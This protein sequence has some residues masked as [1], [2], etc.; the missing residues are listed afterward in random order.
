MRPKKL[1]AIR[2]TALLTLLSIPALQ[3]LAQSGDAQPRIT[4]AVDETKLTL[5]KGNTY[6]LARPEYDQGA[7][8]PS[9]PME[10]MLLV[11]K[12]SPQQEAALEKLMAE[13]LDKSSPNFHRW[14]TPE[15]LGKQF[16]PSD[17]DIQT[18]TSWLGSHGFQIVEVSHGRTVID[19][20]GNAG[21]VQEA[22]H[23]TIHSYIVKSQQHWANSSDPQIPTALS[24]VVAGV[25]TL[26]N[27]PRNPAKVH[28][29]EFRKSKETGKVTA[30]ATANPNF[31]FAGACLGPGTDCYAVG[32]TD[33]AT[34]YNVL[35]RWTAGNDGTGVTI[36]VVGQTDINPQ[37]NASFRSIFG[38]PASH[39]IITQN[40]NTPDPGTIGPG[41]NDDEAEANI[42]TQWSGAVATG[43]TIN[44]VKSAETNAGQGV[45][46]SA[47]YI[48][49][50][51]LAPIMTES[52]GLCEA[53]LGTAGNLFYYQLW[54]QAAGQ[55]I[56]VFI[57]TG[58][59]GSATCDFDT[60]VT[61]A[62]YG[63][64]V[65]GFAST[66]FDVAVGGTDFNDAITQSQYWSA[67]NASGTQTSAL[68]YIPE[69]VWNNTCSSV[70]LVDF[71]FSSDPVTNC[72][73]SQVIQDFQGVA[74]SGGGGGVSVCTQ[75][76]GTDV[77]SCLGGY[78]KPSWQAGPG[79]PVDGKR[80]VPDVSLF[81][82]NGFFNGSFYVI[83]QMDAN[84]GTGSSTSSCDLNSPFFDF[85]GYGG[86]SVATPAMAGIMA[87][88]VQQTG[89]AAQGNPNA[90][91]YAMAKQS[92][93][94]CNSNG[95]QTGSCIYHNLQSGAG[96]N[97][98]P[99]E[100]KTPNCTVTGSNTVGVLP[101]CSTGSGYNLASGLG[102]VNVANFVTGY[103]STVVAPDFSIALTGTA[104]A[105]TT[106]T[107]SAPGGT[108]ATTLT[109]TAENGYS[110][111][112]NSFTC[113]GL[114]AETTCGF[115]PASITSSGS[116]QLTVTTTAATSSQLPMGQRGTPIAHPG[117][118]ARALQIFVI[119]AILFLAT[120]ASMR[121]L[122]WSTLA[123]LLVVGCLLG[124]VACGG[125]GSGGG[126]TNPGTPATTNQ[127]IVVTA[128]DGTNT[129][130]TY[131]L[132]TVQ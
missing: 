108:A 100:P 25:D 49:D 85:Q 92:G 120:Q 65:S 111:T 9:L 122:R 106:L 6:P 118:G 90:V 37:D 101:C 27:F 102:S 18:V 31:T 77:T 75:G 60:D 19:F 98:M 76:D 95:T 86:T 126:G 93:A 30:V 47:Q 35:P 104:P 58:D 116:T 70:L 117:G 56:S 52:Y 130:S 34:I 81:S 80:D 38:L 26:H 2:C 40:P 63:L 36:A 87:L 83:C 127:T 124:I 72:N 3:A 16:G 84:T 121:R 71:Q 89:G 99:C 11:L 50:N 91:L 123:G 66:P 82:G 7:A 57:A 10:N 59:V 44:F 54:Q 114:P 4:Q 68:S 113:T 74:I 22:F 97:A 5:L 29:G 110:G 53:F 32:P 15:Q 94:V 96:S 17:Q 115:S 12:R 62:E 14:L 42:D 39:L 103:Q 78:T 69:V 119:F 46:L 67:T 128:T 8:P 21:Q 109:I 43:A 107:V 64:Q 73:N 132:L 24:P 55:G 125:G 79:V 1:F 129:H 45:D 13:Q 20:S 105:P 112:V 33:F 28:A 51:N 48:I 23:T 131:F 88:V 41:G 61:D